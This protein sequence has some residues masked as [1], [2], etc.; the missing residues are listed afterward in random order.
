[1]T[2]GRQRGGVR[3]VEARDDDA[4]QRIDN[5]LGRHLKGVPRPRLYRAIRRGEVRVNKG[6]VAQTYRLRAGDVVRIPP[7]GTEPAAAA[8][9]AR[10][11]WSAHIVHED[12]HLLVVDKPAG[13][14]VHG[15]SGVSLGVIES[16]RANLPGRPT[17]ELVHRLDRATSGCLV[18]AK[19]RS[20]LRALHE[21]LREG[22]VDKRYLLLV[23]GDWQLGEFEAD[24]PL[25]IHHRRGGE[26]TV[27]VAARG[28][29]A[30]TRFRLCQGY[31]GA[32]LIEAAP[33]TGRTH[34]IRVHAAHVGHP[35]AGDER[36]G[37]EDFNGRLR[38]LGLRRLFLHASS[39]AFDSPDAV[40]RHFSAPLPVELRRL[41]DR[42]EAGALKRSR[43]GKARGS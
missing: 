40:P 19:R 35:I 33:V 26:R 12:K 34:Q 17:L 7:I 3:H 9:A 36:Y 1:M 42:L 39:I 21:R 43:H 38:K 13:W 29:P 30:L 22:L 11:D 24:A 31:A 8:P 20:A 18:V 41:I 14:A 32:S 23:A 5:F 25:D 15:G 37:D 16:L 6:R 2:A 28:R 4:G 10:D 27:R